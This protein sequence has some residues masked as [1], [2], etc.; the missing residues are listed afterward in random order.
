MNYIVGDRV[1]FTKESSKVLE[2]MIVDHDIFD[3]NLTG[4]RRIVVANIYTIRVDDMNY[5]CLDG[6]IIG[7]A[8]DS[9]DIGYYVK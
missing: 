1:R 3:F 7:K 2:G 9:N 8:L 6:N 5:L 4:G